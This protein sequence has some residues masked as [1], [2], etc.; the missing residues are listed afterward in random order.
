MKN[1]FEFN[2]EVFGQ[3]IKRL[4]SGTDRKMSYKEFAD[5]IGASA[6]SVFNWEQGL[7]CIST[8]FLQMIH[9][10]YRCDLIRSVEASAKANG[11]D[12]T[13]VVHLVFSV[14]D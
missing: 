3:V 2:L 7:H 11:K 14:V 12:G 1:N 5:S 13:K 10:V 6:A 9:V 4:R 8:R